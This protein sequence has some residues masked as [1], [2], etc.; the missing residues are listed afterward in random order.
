[1]INNPMSAKSGKGGKEQGKI[2]G[3][4]KI[5]DFSEKSDA[6]GAR[7]VYVLYV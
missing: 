5:L 7:F 2:R 1:M 6:D 3:P 4:S